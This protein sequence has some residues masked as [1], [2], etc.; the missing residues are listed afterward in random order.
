[1]KVRRLLCNNFGSHLF[2]DNISLFL[3][4]PLLFYRL[5]TYWIA[6]LRQKALRIYLSGQIREWRRKVHTGYHKVHR[7]FQRYL[8]L[9]LLLLIL[10]ILR[11]SGKHVVY[12]LLRMESADY[13]KLDAERF[14]EIRLLKLNFLGLSFF[15]LCMI[16]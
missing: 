5:L 12:I 1:D 6:E 11:Q 10:L 15:L 9:Q 16:V 4:L 14:Y 8:L 2:P 7:Q 13:P 3:L